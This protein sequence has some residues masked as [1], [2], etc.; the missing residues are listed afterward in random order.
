MRTITLSKSGIQKVRGHSKELK[1]AD[2]E[3]SIKSIPPGEWCFFGHASLP[4]LW[5]GHINPMIDEKFVCAYLVKSFSKDEAS[6]LSV[7]TLITETL[8]NAFNR[9]NIF[10]GYGKNARLFYGSFDGLTGLIIDGFSDKALIQINTAGLDKYRLLIKQVTETFLGGKA[11]F[12]DNPKYR[13]KEF[14]PIHEV[15]A[16]PVLNITEN[17]IKFTLRPEVLQ[18]V[19]FYYDHRENRQQLI[20]LL[21][22]LNKCPKKAIDLF[23]YLGAWGLCAVKHGVEYCEFVDQGDFNEELEHSLELNNLKGKGKFIRQ[24]VFKY[25]DEQISKNNKYDLILC[26]P[27][28]FAKNPTQK[29]QAIEGYNKLHRK[30]FKIASPGSILAFSSC[31]HYVTS[32]EFH[33]T[34]TDSAHKEGRKIQLL[35]QGIQGWDHPI[36]HLSERGN[37]IKSFFYYME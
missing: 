19:G 11:Y 33:K 9:R 32:E 30:V 13:E 12:L 15:E 20:H 36:S 18:K 29:N 23:C 27:P 6:Q 26:D 34:I 16:L 21:E 2:F 1:L 10:K 5:L 8:N 4:Q 14:L 22:R 37:Y 7:D 24:D 3:E 28:A 31:T 35:H 17:N 25:L